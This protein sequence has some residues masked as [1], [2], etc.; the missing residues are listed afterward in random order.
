MQALFS[1]V[2]E[3]PLLP[4]VAAFALIPPA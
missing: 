2:Q 3:A 1:C 4:A